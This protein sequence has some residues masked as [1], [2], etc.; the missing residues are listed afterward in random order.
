MLNHGAFITVPPYSPQGQV[1]SYCL[2]QDRPAAGRQAV[3]VF[4]WSQSILWIKVI[5][6]L[7]CTSVRKGKGCAY[8]YSNSAFAEQVMCLGTSS[9]HSLQLKGR[10]KVCVWT[11]SVC[12]LSV[13]SH[14]RDAGGPKCSPDVPARYCSGCCL[15]Y[16]EQGSGR[17]N[18]GVKQCP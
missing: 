17:I 1:A 14:S 8:V 7:K 18:A 4:L 2:G 10:L 9:P 16:N 5:H 3:F 12:G 6:C 15:H 13:W 11:L